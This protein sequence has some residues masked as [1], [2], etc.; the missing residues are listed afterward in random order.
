[1]QEPEVG[2]KPE[3]P[4]PTLGLRLA[5]SGVVDVPHSPVIRFLSGSREPSTL[6]QRAP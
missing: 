2:S 6:Q 3:G 4:E 5:S 1:M